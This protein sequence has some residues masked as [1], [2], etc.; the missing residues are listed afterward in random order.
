MD[1]KTTQGR[2]ALALNEMDGEIFTSKAAQKRALDHLNRAYELIRR[3]HF[4][5][6]L[7]AAPKAPMGDNEAACARS[8]WIDDRSLPFDLHQIRAKHM[9][10]AGEWADEIHALTELRETLKL[11][12]IRKPEPKAKDERIEKVETSI[13]SEMERIGK[14]YHEALDLGR[15]F[16]G[17]NVSANVHMVVNQ[18]GT[19]FIRAFYYL[20]GK[21]MPLNVILA[22]ADTLAREKE[23]RA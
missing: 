22:A 21:R 5:A 6:L 10:I 13:R 18:Y 19:R 8:I 1:R 11:T 16:N 3:R 9:P 23:G 7:E 12:E 17:L 2:I 14:M 4:D 20:E 15:L